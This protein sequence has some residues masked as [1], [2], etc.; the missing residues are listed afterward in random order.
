MNARDRYLAVYDDNARKKLDRVPTFVQY[1]RDEFITQ[2]K[3]ELFPKNKEPLLTN[4]Y[5]EAPRVLGFDAVFAGFPPSV[6]FKAI[7][8]E[9]DK[10]NKIRIN[11][12]GQATRKKSEY[13]AG[14]YIHSL[15]IL[16]NLRANFTR[17]DRSEGIKKVLKIYEK[18]APTIFSVLQVE[19]IFDRVWQAMGMS[20]FSRHF[21]KRTKLYRELLKFYAEILRANIQGLIDVTGGRGKMVNILDDV[22]FKGQ[23]MIS[24][25]RWDQD[26]LPFY[27]EIN[28]IISDAGMIPQN[29]SDG[30]VTKLI[31]SLQKA[32]FLGLQGWEGG[33]DPFYINENFPDFVVIGFGDVS[34][35]LPFGTLEQVDVHVKQLMDAL[36]ENRHF[37]LAPS[38]VIF[39]EIPL[40]NVR[41][42]MNAAKKHGNY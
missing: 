16:D 30:D 18:I 37:V 32:G 6:S 40:E 14:G 17:V 1:I 31:P 22:A 15:E 13:Y 42:F 25:E 27:K 5:F 4:Q 35:I 33:A 41:A 9:D 34:D 20:V 12:S 21:R 3:E 23:L 28:S 39:K 26:F 29:H 24:P 10:G 19:G 7:R 8:I 38:T 2:H 36:K 11:E